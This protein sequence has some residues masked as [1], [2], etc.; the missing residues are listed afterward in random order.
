MNQPHADR[1]DHSGQ[2]L[3]GRGAPGAHAGRTA[4]SA[5]AGG[6]TAAVA[7]ACAAAD[8]P[9]LVAIFAFMGTVVAA[10]AA[11]IS[12]SAGEILARG[13]AARRL[14]QAAAEEARQTDTS[15]LQ[16]AVALLLAVDPD[17]SESARPPLTDGDAPPET[18]LTAL[19]GA[20]GPPAPEGLP[21]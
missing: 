10:I 21:P 9:G 18:L 11:V 4:A 17:G 12:S 15:R 5:A 8:R 6:F 14:L 2:P 1:R 13:H 20:P 16:G 7:V 3:T 19:P